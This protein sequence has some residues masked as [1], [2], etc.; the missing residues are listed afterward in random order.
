[1]DEVFAAGVAALFADPWLAADAVYEPP[2]GSATTVR[3]ILI[4]TE[5][6]AGAGNVRV[7]QGA[8]RI[9]LQVAEVPQQPPEG[10]RVTI[11]ART[12]RIRQAV[13]DRLRLVWECDCDPA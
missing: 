7:F 8:F 11:A 5:S 3:A 10:A 1:M 13:R 2:G 6:L 12:F 9:D 4:R